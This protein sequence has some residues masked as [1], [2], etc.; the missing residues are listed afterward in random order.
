VVLAAQR[1]TSAGADA[2]LE[3]LCRS[4]WYPLYAY[5][6]RYGH[7][8]DD[9]QDLTQE[10]FARLLS[11]DWLQAAAQ[12]RGRFR[13]FLLI[14]L[15]RFLANE[16]H[17]ATAQK[18]GGGVEVLP[19]DTVDAEQRYAGEPV[20]TADE[21]FDRRWAITL[22]DH[23]L[24][25]LSSEFTASGKQSEFKVLKDWLTAGR[26]EIPYAEVAGQLGTTEGAARAAVHRLRKRFRELFREN[27]AQT[28]ASPAGL[29]DEMRHLATVLGGG[30]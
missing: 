27:I 20:L 1:E 19:L 14:A 7:G 23:T 4:Y 16:W 21:V 26:G 6:R 30:A 24:G 22:L 5:V 17:H 8:P 11:R 18:R 10:F 13:T 9:A 3:T 12:E 2:A 15:K 29:E 25:R 28:L